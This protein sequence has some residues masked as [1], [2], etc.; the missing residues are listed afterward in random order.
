[1]SSEPIRTEVS[2]L[3]GSTGGTTPIPRRPRLEKLT[4]RTGTSS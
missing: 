2:W 1:M 3:L 4:V